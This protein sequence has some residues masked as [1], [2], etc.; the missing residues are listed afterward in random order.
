MRCT[1]CGRRIAVYLNEVSGRY[2][3]HVI[4]LALHKAT[5]AKPKEKNS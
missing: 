1:T 4:P 3:A 5:L 2:L